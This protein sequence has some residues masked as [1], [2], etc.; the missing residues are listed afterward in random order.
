MKK[1]IGVFA[2]LLLLQCSL[3]ALDASVTFATFKANAI[4]Y[5]EVG[6]FVVGTTV[7]YAP[8]DS[9]H[10]QASVEVVILFKQKGEIVRFDKFQLNSPL[11]VRPKDF[12]DLKRYS[13]DSGEYELEVTMQDVNQPENTK[14][15]QAGF[16]IDYQ[17]D[18]VLQSDIQLLSS[19]EPSEEE[20]PFVKNGYHM[21]PF[22]SIFTEKMPKN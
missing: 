13:L 20:G 12:I 17:R 21:G 19:V 15:Y 18:G 11:V 1:I 14:T 3:R 16:S 22:P 6:L 4:Q 2:G 7:T 5:V 9:V 10:Q 8:V